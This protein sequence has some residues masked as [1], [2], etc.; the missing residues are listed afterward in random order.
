MRVDVQRLVMQVRPGV[1]TAEGG[2][3]HGSV[4]RVDEG[5]VLVPYWEVLKSVQFDT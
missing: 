2:V 4:V 5:V 1:E 3:G